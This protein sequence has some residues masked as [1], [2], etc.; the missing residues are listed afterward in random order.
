MA[1]VE[2]LLLLLLLLLLYE[3]AVDIVSTGGCEEK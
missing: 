2:L 1:F 3:G